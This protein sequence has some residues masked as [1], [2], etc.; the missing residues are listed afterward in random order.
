MLEEKCTHC[1]I[2]VSSHAAAQ[3]R[4]E[5]LN[6]VGALFTNITHDHLDYHHTF[7][8]YIRAKKIF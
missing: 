8:S 2:E 4:I 6:F 5:G 3:G 1:F 7:E